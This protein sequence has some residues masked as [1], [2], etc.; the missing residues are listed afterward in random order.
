MAAAGFRA[1]A[2]AL[3]CAGCTSI[4]VDARTFE[5]TRWRVTAIDGKP[6]PAGG[7]YRMEFAGGRIGGRFGCN[8][9]GGHYAVSGKSLSA[10]QVI[11][12]M[13]ACPEPAMSFERRGLS[14]LQQPMQWTFAGA[15]LT[16]SNAAGSIALERQP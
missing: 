11:S 14:I 2:L 8:S 4:A 15:R 7:D 12:T 5:G 16:L 9:W 1:A 3:A 13:M 6:T 10:R